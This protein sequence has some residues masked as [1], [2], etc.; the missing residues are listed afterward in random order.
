[1]KSYL[2]STL[3]LLIFIS[4]DIIIGIFRIRVKEE[5]IYNTAFFGLKKYLIHC[6]TEHWVSVLSGHQEPIKVLNKQ[7][8]TNKTKP[9]TYV[10]KAMQHSLQMLRKKNFSKSYLWAGPRRNEQTADCCIMSALCRPDRSQN[11]SE[12]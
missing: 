12:Q 11:P 6:R 4:L 5:E 1:M 2:G 3:I 10:I 7:C 9:H 8:T